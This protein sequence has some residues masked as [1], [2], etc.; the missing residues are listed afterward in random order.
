MGPREITPLYTSGKT[1][2]QRRGKAYPGWYRSGTTFPTPPGPPPV[3]AWLLPLHQLPQQGK[4]D[5]NLG[6]PGKWK[7]RDTGL[8]GPAL[9]QGDRWSLTKNTVRA[10]CPHSPICMPSPDLWRPELAAVQ[11]ASLPTQSIRYGCYLLSSYCVPGT[12]LSKHH[13]SLR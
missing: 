7:P 6:V 9:C 11:L 1:S 13:D 8:L 12:V 4:E 3:P 5:E 2:A 10:P